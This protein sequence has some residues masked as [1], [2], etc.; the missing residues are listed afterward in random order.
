VVVVLAGTNDI[1]GNTGPMTLDDIDANYRSMAEL[2]TANGIQVVMSSVLPVH[3]YTPQAH[4][5]FLQRSPAQILELN[6]RLREYCARTGCVYLDYYG[7]MI[8]AQGALRR[9]L[10]DDGLHPNESGYN[11]M[12]PL[13]EAAIASVLARH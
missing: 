5:Y 3:D 1:A 4:E 10:A 11:V 2:A 12:V 6:R 7:A 9:E 13:A 8:D